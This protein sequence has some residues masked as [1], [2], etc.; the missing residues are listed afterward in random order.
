MDAAEEALRFVVGRARENLNDEHMLTLACTR[1]LE[2]VGEAASQ[3]SAELR[4]RNSQVPW[5]GM[6]GMRNR[7]VHAYYDINV[8]VLW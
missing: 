3:V 8:D 1:L 4:D 5:N 6:T 2:V 7:L